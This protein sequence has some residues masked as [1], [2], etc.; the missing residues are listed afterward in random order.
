M[1]VGSTSTNLANLEK[2]VGAEVPLLGSP[3]Q[4]EL[5]S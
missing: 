5:K 2:I 3:T 1:H 4:D